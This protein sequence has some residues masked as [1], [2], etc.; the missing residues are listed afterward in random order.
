[1]HDTHQTPHTP[2]LTPEE[3]DALIQAYNRRDSEPTGRQL[4][5]PLMGVALLVLTLGM[6]W[7]WG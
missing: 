4:P 3:L 7:W 1:M 6:G 5:W 2:L